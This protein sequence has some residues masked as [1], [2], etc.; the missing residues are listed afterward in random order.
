MNAVKKYLNNDNFENSATQFLS[1]ESL[2]SPSAGPLESEKITFASSLK[3]F[4][5]VVIIDANDLGQKV[6]GNSTGMDN[7]LIEKIFSDN[8]M[9]Q[10]NEQTP[11]VLVFEKK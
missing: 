6:L 9:G 3:N 10:A 1:H 8:P 4:L 5:G 7:K 11:L 2:T